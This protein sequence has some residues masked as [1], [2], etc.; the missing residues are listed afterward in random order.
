[1]TNRTSKIYDV[2]SLPPVGTLPEK[3]HAW[4]LRQEWLGDPATAFHE[5]IVPVPDPSSM[6]PDTSSV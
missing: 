3:M 4:T 2:G 1:M 6:A 5:E